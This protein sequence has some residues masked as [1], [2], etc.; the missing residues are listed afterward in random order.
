MWS[1]VVAATLTFCSLLLFI[2]R[3]LWRPEVP[4][5]DQ[6]PSRPTQADEDTAERRLIVLLFV[7]HLAGI[8]QH[9]LVTAWAKT[10]PTPG[11]A[12]DPLY[13]TVPERPIRVGGGPAGERRFLSALRGPQGQAIVFQRLGSCCPFH[14]HLLDMYDIRYDSLPDAIVLYLDMYERD[15]PKAPLGLTRE[16]AESLVG[17]SVDRHVAED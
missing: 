8:A 2:T 6:D 17:E 9:P 1:M 10:E 16:T 7:L 15:S 12:S 3:V 11:T 5:P 14:G 13:G 4:E